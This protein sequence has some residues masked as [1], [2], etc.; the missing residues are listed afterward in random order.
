MVYAST[1]LALAAIELFVH[2]EPN[3]APQD[4]VAIAAD[5][6]EGEPAIRWDKDKLPPQWS[7]DELGPGRALGDAWIRGN[8]SLA[9]FVPSVPI[10]QEWNVL[11]NALHPSMSE[12]KSKSTEPFHFDARM[13]LTR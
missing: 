10:P 8:Q 9:V 12:L 2:L 5:L 4:L 3:Q 11:I 13:F 1:S 7:T 6:P